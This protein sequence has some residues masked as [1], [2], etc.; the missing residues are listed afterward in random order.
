MAEV[1]RGSRC[2][3]TRASPR[4]TLATAPAHSRCRPARG[5]DA[6]GEPPPVELHP[7][8]SSTRRP[9]ARRW[10][11]PCLVGV[12]AEDQLQ[13]RLEQQA[14]QLPLT[15]APRSGGRRRSPVTLCPKP[16]NS[17]T[18]RCGGLGQARC[19]SS[20]VRGRL[21]LPPDGPSA[22]PD[23]RHARNEDA[24]FGRHAGPV[25]RRRAR[26]RRPPGQICTPSP[27]RAKARGRAARPSPC[28][29][30]RMRQGQGRL[31]SSAGSAAV[32]SR[33]RAP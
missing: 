30:S 32:A 13:R 31:R 33:Y 6:A 9:A 11:T 18:V 10:I 23:C 22:R 12:V 19:R 2:G 24:Q 8:S 16:G 25:D 7:M 15:R 1:E 14:A 17:G 5:H 20:T 21:R 29:S 27:C 26:P 3:W 4:C 28:S